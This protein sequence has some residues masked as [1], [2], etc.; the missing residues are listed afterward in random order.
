M[1]Y[2]VHV[3][4]IQALCSDLI[5]GGSRAGEVQ[6]LSVA[7]NQVAVKG[8]LAN[9]LEGQTLTANIQGAYHYLNRA[10]PGYQMRVCR[11]SSGQAH[12]L[13]FP[14]SALPQLS[15]AEEDRSTGTFLLL[16]HDPKK[17]QGIFFRQLNARLDLPLH[18]SWQAWL[19]NLFQEAGWLEKLTTL[20]GCFEGYL[21]SLQPDLLQIEISQALAEGHPEL[22]ACFRQAS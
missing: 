11:L 21:V 1:L 9:L 6:Y 19:W 2:H 10:E 3:G 16:S 5:V 7:G 18:E 17:T 22:S 12:G 13:L 4:G 8:I 14:H 15:Q 20:A